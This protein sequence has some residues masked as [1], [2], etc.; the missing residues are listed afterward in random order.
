M[1]YSCTIDP[2]Y[3]VPCHKPSLLRSR[4][5][6]YAA[7]NRAKALVGSPT[8]TE[9]PISFG[10]ACNVDLSWCWFRRNV[11]QFPGQSALSWH[12][13]AISYSKFI[14]CDCITGLDKGISDG[15]QQLSLVVCVQYLSESFYKR[16]NIFLALIVSNSFV[17]NAAFSLAQKLLQLFYNANSSS[18]PYR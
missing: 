8:Y 17:K 7:Y 6:L 12:G 4:T 18:S 2:Q 3:D 14:E 9:A 13:N 1:V 10:A 5:R 15:Y 11:M 16:C